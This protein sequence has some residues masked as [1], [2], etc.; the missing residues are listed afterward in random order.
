MVSRAPVGKIEAFRKRMGWRFP[1]AS[2]FGN[3]F[4]RDF[5]VSFTPEEM[6]TGAVHYNYTT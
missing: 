3:S 6:A 5:G 1:W 4:N 2:S